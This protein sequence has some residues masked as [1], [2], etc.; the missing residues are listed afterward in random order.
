MNLQPI[1]AAST[2]VQI[3]LAFALVTFVLGIVMF[4]RRK[5]TPSH[6]AIGRFWMVLIL[7]AAFS[8][9]WITGLAGE[10]RF[11]VIHILSVITILGAFGAVL[12]IRRGHVRTHRNA[13]IGLFM[14]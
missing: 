9:F 6:K 1:W 5:G 2:A 14:G 7:V 10:G 3:H 13:V 12:A 4:T 11:S 8:S